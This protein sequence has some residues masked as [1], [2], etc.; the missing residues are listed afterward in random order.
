[1][2][3]RQWSNACSAAFSFCLSHRMD[4][5]DV[6]L[7]PVWHESHFYLLVA[8]PRLK[9]WE[10]YNTMGWTKRHWEY[11]WAFKEYVY[12]EFASRGWAVVG[13]EMHNVASCPQQGNSDDC[14]VFVMAIA[15][16]L[17]RRRE[18]RFTQVDMWYVLSPEDSPR[19]ISTPVG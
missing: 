8:Y 2:R 10:Y 19:H 14:R 1:M 13:W 11:A 15:D 16:H 12:M 6:F 5:F 17:A 3:D 4:E 9:R 7:F 18:L